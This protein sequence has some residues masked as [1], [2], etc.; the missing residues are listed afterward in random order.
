[1]SIADKKRKALDESSTSSTPPMSS[2]DRASTSPSP[3]PTTDEPS[4][5]AEQGRRIEAR[6]M[7][8]TD[9]MTELLSQSRSSGSS[10]APADEELRELLRE[11]LRRRAEEGATDSSRADDAIGRVAEAAQARTVE[12]VREGVRDGLD[13]DAL[14]R[15]LCNDLAEQ[16]AEAVREPLATAT[17]DVLR[18][19]ERI[20]DRQAEQNLRAEKMLERR[21]K[22]QARELSRWAR[23]GRTANAVLPFAAPLVMILAVI[24]L[25]IT[26][27]P[28][29]AAVGGVGG[30]AVVTGF[31]GFVLVLVVAVVWGGLRLR[32]I[33]KRWGS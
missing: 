16:I 17:A 26:V 21:E 32:A 6:M 12:A 2:T 15:D 11:D 7:Q 14:A 29:A 22:L 18:R 30:L 5:S 9:G 28:G 20:T 27:L 31:V 13:A 24:G 33:F 4:L 19:A 25:G 3:S 1:M 8:V 23:V 10:A